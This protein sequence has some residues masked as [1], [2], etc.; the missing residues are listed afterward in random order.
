MRPRYYCRENDRR[1]EIDGRADL[2]GIDF[3]EVLDDAGMLPDE[4]QRTLF[5]HFIN[6]PIGLSIGP[7]NVV[8]EGGERDAFRD[9]PVADARVAVDPRSGSSQAVLVVDVRYPGDYSIY[10]LRLIAGTE[11]T[12]WFDQLDPM[13]RSVD[14]S[15][16]VNCRSHFDC[17]RRPICPPKVMREPAISY[18]AR[19][20]KS[21]RK[22]MLDRMAV[23]MPQWRERNAADAGIVLLELLAYVGDYLSYRQDAV[24][25]EAY[26]ETARQRVSVR[27]HARLVDYPMHDGCS[28][29]CWIHVTVRQ[30]VTLAG[31]TAFFSV[32]P[33]LETRIDS[34][35]EG[36]RQALASDAEP[37]AAMDAATLY[38]EHNQMEFYTWGARQCCLPK[39]SCSAYL[40]GD[41]P[42]L[43][44]GMVLI[45][46]EVRDPSSG[47]EADA[48]ARH[49]HAVRL[50]R[51]TRTTDPIGG[52]F[53]L[54]PTDAAVDVT[55][56]AWSKEDRLPFALCISAERDDEHDGG[57]VPQVSVALGNIV[58]ADHGSWVRAEPLGTVPMPTLKR[59][60]TVTGSDE[61]DCNVDQPSTRPVTETVSPRFRPVL[62]ERWITQAAPAPSGQPPAS[63]Q[64]AMTWEMADVLPVIVL[65]S[66][67]DNE[68]HRQWHP[69]RDLLNSSSRTEFV[70]EVE[71]DGRTYLRFGDGQHGTRPSPGEAFTADYRIGN[72]ARG[73]VGADTIVHIVSND[74]AIEQVANPLPAR[75]GVNMESIDSVMAR[76]PQAFRT[77]KRAVTLDDYAQAASSHRGVQ[78]AA[79]RLQWTG[80][81]HTLFISVDRMGGAPIDRVFETDLRKLLEPLRM[82]GH[83]VEIDPPR[84]VPLVID[85]T[86]DIHP[87]Y[88]RSGVRE[89]LLRRF[90][91][92]NLPGGRK[93]LLHP[94]N[95][96]FG[97]SVYLSPMI[98]A[99]QAT[100]GVEGVDVTRFERMDAPGGQG[101]EEGRLTMGR[102]EIARLDND[103]NFPGRGTFTLNLRGGR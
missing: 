1:D 92:D 61:G 39:G 71:T 94:D 96:T 66:T 57:Y 31:G 54:P 72:G 58:L 23:L 41:F 46:K 70:A 13:M 88:E 18:L 16:K 32:V 75:G 85:M 103:P 48:D 4:R 97:Q 26:L 8:V 91:P 19:D 65:H 86:V 87:T 22:L 2:N 49:R 55:E 30:T 21:F 27:R 81:W 67:M 37:F 53:D 83:D 74:T 40:R 84:M 15:F 98:A 47:S 42:N 60:M 59:V 76:A 99:A 14:F 36:H 28:A 5:V 38:P 79:A 52:R 24:A 35:S 9:P 29:R 95:F 44:P 102:F 3:I 17:C 73:N 82:A 45:F 101:L 90:S 43:E 20:F 6:D 33:G 69:Q 63:A 56:I 34:D 51:V 78:K 77:Q 89:A 25:T 11:N 62:K 68:Q 10:A 12:T 7:E 50:I 93:G 80:S 100:D 64:A